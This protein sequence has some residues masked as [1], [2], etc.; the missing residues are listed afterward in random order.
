MGKD[1]GFEYLRKYEPSLFKRYRF[2]I[3]VCKVIL[4]GTPALFLFL[5]FVLAIFQSINAG[6]TNVGADPIGAGIVAFFLLIGFV[7]PWIALSL[8]PVY[9]VAT[10][11]AWSRDRSLNDRERIAMNEKT[12]QHFNVEQAHSAKLLTELQARAIGAQIVAEAG[13]TVYNNSFNNSTV[14]DRS[15]LIESLN[16]VDNDTQLAD[17]LQVVAGIVQNSGNA[18][19]IQTLNEFNKK[20]AAKD[21]KITLRALWDQPVKLVPDVVAIGGAASKIIEFLS[22][23][24]I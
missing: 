19:A 17:A 14:V 8:V 4:F 16:R 9:V 12:R 15:T 20:I 23:T 22:G 6:P 21:S 5:S 11:V 2:W 24:K 7:Y 13:A 3:K 10:Y 1:L 18:L